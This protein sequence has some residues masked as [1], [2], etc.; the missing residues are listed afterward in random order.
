[1]QS[2]APFIM[3]QSL[4]PIRAWHSGLAEHEDHVAA[5]ADF[6]FHPDATS[7]T[8]DDLTAKRQADSRPWILLTSVQ[9][10]KYSKDL[11]HLSEWDADAIVSNGES[12][13]LPDGFS[14][15]MD[16]RRIGT[17]KSKRI[18]DEMAKDH[19]PMAAVYSQRRQWSDLELGP[20]GGDELGQV[21][22]GRGDQLNE[23]R[24][25]ARVVVRSDP[26]I[27]S[28]VSDHISHTHRCASCCLQVPP[29]SV[30]EIGAEPRGNKR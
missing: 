23:G 16:T 27:C 11:L 2:R 25:L 1:M 22:L 5:Y 8:L 28:Q 29:R 17:P 15:D 6:R 20:R 26:G 13:L 30:V 3:H 9:P 21:L 10:V 24:W 7:M 19:G 18:G 14:I 12:P 4:A